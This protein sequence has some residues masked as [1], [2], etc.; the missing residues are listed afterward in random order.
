MRFNVLA[1]GLTIIAGYFLPVGASVLNSRFFHERVID[2][3]ID[4]MG[5]EI[6]EVS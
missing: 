5:D 1:L 2:Y 4:C 3:V 6:Y